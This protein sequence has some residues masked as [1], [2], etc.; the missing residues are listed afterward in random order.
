MRTGAAGVSFIND[1]NA[2][3]GV[4]AFIQ[5]LRFQHSP[6]AV[7]HGFGHA[8]FDQLQGADIADDNCLICINDSP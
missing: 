3:T 6:A 8:R 2:S 7:E 4:L 1:S 5:K